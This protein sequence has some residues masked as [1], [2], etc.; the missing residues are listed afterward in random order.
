MT[1][2]TVSQCTNF[3]KETVATIV[4]LIEKEGAICF[5]CFVIAWNSDVYG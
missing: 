2:T 1:T 3:S 5:C 4:N